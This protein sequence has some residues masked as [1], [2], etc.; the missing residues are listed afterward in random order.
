MEKLL[1][2]ICKRSRGKA[3]GKQI[4]GVQIGGCALL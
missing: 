2:I 1:V 4:T 3:F